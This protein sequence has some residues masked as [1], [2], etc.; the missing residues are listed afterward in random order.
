MFKFSGGASR[1][2]EDTEKYSLLYITSPWASESQ[3]C[4]QEGLRAE[5]CSSF[6]PTCDLVSWWDWIKFWWLLVPEATLEAAMTQAI[7]AMNQAMHFGG[8]KE[9]TRFFYT[10]MNILYV[11]QWFQMLRW[12]IWKKTVLVSC[13]ESWGL[14]NLDKHSNPSSYNSPN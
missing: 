13:T 10:I 5:T 4:E 3:P 9:R 12:T 1:R 7:A 11:P 6:P 8:L 2:H 14:C